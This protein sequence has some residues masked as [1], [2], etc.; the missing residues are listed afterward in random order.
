VPERATPSGG[1]ERRSEKSAEIVVVGSG[2]LMR[3][4]PNPPDEGSNERE[5]STTTE[6]GKARHQMPAGTGL[7]LERRGEAPRVQRSGEAGRAGVDPGTQ[8]PAAVTRRCDLNFSNRRMRTRMSGGVGGGQ[9]G[10]PAAPYPDV[11]P[12][13]AMTWR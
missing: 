2:A 1:M 10:S 5:S 11:C 3:L 4:D 9:P 7:A 8:A 6:C 12:A 13:W